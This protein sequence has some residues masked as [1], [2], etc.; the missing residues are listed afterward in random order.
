MTKYFP[1][2]LL[3]LLMATFLVCL[4]ACVMHVHIY[5]AEE[6]IEPTCLETGHYSRTCYCG[7]HYKGEIP[8]KGHTPVVDEAVPAT[9][10]QMG[11]TEGSHCSDCKTVFTSQRTIQSLPHNFNQN[12]RCYVCQS[13]YYS[14]GLTYEKASDGS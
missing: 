13:P 3:L 12:N 2:I 5:V 7:V 4:S 1:T 14:Q 10:T 8:A 9:C 11:L 6:I